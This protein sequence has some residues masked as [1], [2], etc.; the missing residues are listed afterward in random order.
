MAISD[1]ALWSDIHIRPDQTLEP[2]VAYLSRSKS[3]LLGVHFDP[4]VVESEEMLK[5]SDTIFK[6]S[7]RIRTLRIANNS[8]I[9]SIQFPLLR[10]AIV[11]SPYLESLEIHSN[12]GAMDTLPRLFGGQLP[13]LK[14]LS[15]K[16]YNKWPSG[17]FHNLSSV[18]LEESHLIDATDFL[19]FLD[20]NPELEDLY[21]SLSGLRDDAS[22]GARISNLPRL[23][24]LTLDECDSPRILS[25]VRIPRTQIRLTRTW[26][27]LKHH[28][29]SVNLQ[30]APDFVL[31]LPSDCSNINS[32]QDIRLGKIKKN[33]GG[34]TLLTGGGD[35]SIEIFEEYSMARQIPPHTIWCNAVLAFTRHAIFSDLEILIF[36]SS[37]NSY[38]SD[39]ESNE[40]EP[41]S[42][43]SDEEFDNL[44]DFSYQSVPHSVFPSLFGHLSQL[45]HITLDDYSTIPALNALQSPAALSRL[46][47]VVCPLLQT[48]CI[49]T[50]HFSWMG[51][52]NDT[53]QRRRTIGFPVAELI[54]YVA[55]EESRLDVK[56]MTRA[57]WGHGVGSIRVEVG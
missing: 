57:W 21:M 36:E 15:L 1:A 34:T 19:D 20:G 39:T 13:R 35:S 29:N 10:E 56:R 32:F 7:H 55:T 43:E 26:P 12:R 44:A 31:S 5:V 8:Y 42:I 11:P 30:A 33:H 47:G 9:D 16:S 24:R 41:D 51:A 3:S 17:M 40:S 6:Q 54:I 18:R 52:L 45:K 48:L 53:L 38:G 14:Y 28:Y 2:I 27:F 49:K 22:I 25:R 37:R 23:S 46:G 4:S 50:F